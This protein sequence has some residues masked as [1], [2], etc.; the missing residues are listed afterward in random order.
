MSTKTVNQTRTSSTI[1]III[2]AY[3]VADYLKEAV[4][5]IVNQTVKPSEVII[6]DDGS[7]DGTSGILE[8]YHG[9]RNW[10]I[11]KTANNGL[12]PARNLGRIVAK[13]EYLYFF[14]SDDLLESNFIE[15]MYQ[16]ISQYDKPDMI[17]FS[18][19]SFHEK[20][21]EHQ[22]SPAY[23]RT[24]SGCFE[25][26][27]GLISMMHRQRES[28]AS[29]CLYVSK[30][31][32]WSKNRLL[33]PPILH[34]DE[35]V[36]FPLLCLSQRAVMLPNVYFRRRVRA[37][38]IMTSEVDARNVSGILRVVY[39][40]M[41]FMSREPELV[42]PDI[43]AW[44]ARVAEFGARYVY[45]CR[46]TGVPLSWAAVIASSITARSAKILLRI[47]Y[48]FLPESVQDLLRRL[49]YALR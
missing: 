4:D 42:E 29:A 7:S 3:N 22:L 34:E 5:S 19:Q 37:G 32:V 13:S 14:D 24:I 39:E 17:L 20:N 41:E 44:R 2:P 47:A 6:V 38:S 43:E 48:S 18:G 46:E 9:Y 45:L 27:A 49:K 16:V 1:A 25:R 8:R 30:A 28:F 23:Q 33:F 12:G 40:T 31:E 21:F 10:K 36:L 11:I 35:A 15:H 26:N